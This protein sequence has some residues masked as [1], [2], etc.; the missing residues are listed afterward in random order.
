MMPM[1]V[2]LVDG[3]RE[4]AALDVTTAGRLAALGVTH[5]T[6]ARDRSTEAVVLEGWAFDAI[7][8]VAEASALVGGRAATRTLQPVLQVLIS[9]AGWAGEP[10]RV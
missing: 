5:V 4:V 8:H 10:A 1:L 7:T 2:V 9:P 6:V 3:R